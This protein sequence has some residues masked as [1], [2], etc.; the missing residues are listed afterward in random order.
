MLPVQVGPPD[1][2]FI[3]STIAPDRK[4]V[5]SHLM[6]KYWGD[7]K[8]C[9][10]S[11][12]QASHVLAP[13]D[14]PMPGLAEDTPPARKEPLDI[15]R[16]PMNPSHVLECNATGLQTSTVLDDGTSCH[17]SCRAVGCDTPAY[18]N[19][20]CQTHTN[21]YQQL[22]IDR[23]P[24]MSSWHYDPFISFPVELTPRIKE[25]LDHGEYH[26]R[27]LGPDS[28]STPLTFHIA[29]SDRRPNI[30]FY[31]NIQLRNA[32][33]CPA[34][35][36]QVVANIL[37]WMRLNDSSKSSQEYE[38]KQELFHQAKAT[39]LIRDMISTGSMNEGL[40]SASE[41]EFFFIVIPQYDSYLTTS[42]IH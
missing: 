20:L 30:I 24:T 37:K 10:R 19:L 31:R 38:E 15:C 1:L 9:R 16:A 25:V 27:W 40:V 11:R 6:K 12:P 32:L 22:P 18:G 28:N 21:Q 36:H 14:Q 17:N 13:R 35:F 8:R 39:S 42:I 4:L 7:K 3:N 26:T 2:M 29:F 5:R 41:F 33:M 23:S 34:S